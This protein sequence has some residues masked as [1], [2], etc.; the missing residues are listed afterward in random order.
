MKFVKY[1]ILL[2]LLLV[3]TISVFVATKSG[4]Y[5]VNK[6]IVI[7]VSKKIVYNYLAD[8]KNWNSINPGK[9]QHNEIQNI[10]KIDTATLEQNIILD[11]VNTKIEVKIQDTLRNKTLVKLYTI[12]NL[13]FKDKFLSII[14]KGQHNNIGQKFEDYLSTANKILT[15]ETNSFSVKIDGFVNRDTIFYI[16]K[17]IICK[18]DELP[19]K[20][21]SVIPKLKKLLN[22][23][24]TAQNG[25]TF[26]VYHEVDSV[27]N[28]V[29]LSVALPTKQKVFT[30]SESDV[31]TGQI[32]PFQAVKATLIGNYIHK[33]KVYKQMKSYLLS[34][35][36]EI[37]IK[38]KKIEYIPVN[39][40]TEKSASKWKTEIYLPVKPFINIKK[41]P[42]IVNDSIVTVPEANAETVKQ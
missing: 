34:N 10:I 25:D 21:K 16:Q 20:L 6:S 36:L 35:K 17:P 12:G 9:D 30:S 29:K 33:E 11:E 37:S 7:N 28:I 26:L 22:A 15:T 38:T 42:K 19:N 27:S 2:L 4:N 13:T 24:N 8:S 18:T 23:T 32:N 39:I 1:F 40:S 31:F 5:N 3:L 41:K 14:N